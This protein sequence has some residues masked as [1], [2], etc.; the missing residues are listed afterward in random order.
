MYARGGGRGNQELRITETLTSQKNNT[1]LHT[2]SHT[3][4]H[5]HT[6]LVCH[7]GCV[8]RQARG[9]LPC[10]GGVKEP[11]L[12]LHHTHTA[13]TDG[14]I[15]RGQTMA[16]NCMAA[17]YAESAMCVSVRAASPAQGCVRPLQTRAHAH[18]L[19]TYTHTV[20]AHAPPPHTQS[21]THARARAHTCSSALN[22]C[23]RMRTLRVEPATVN[24]PPLMPVNTPSSPLTHSRARTVR[25]NLWLQVR[26]GV[27]VCVCVCARA[28]VCVHVCMLCCT[29]LSLNCGFAVVVAHN[30]CCCGREQHEEQC[31][32]EGPPPVW[33]YLC[34]LLL[35]LLL[36]WYYA[37]V[38][39]GPPPTCLAR[40]M[41]SRSP[42]PCSMAPWPEG[43]QAFAC[44]SIHVHHPI[45]SVSRL[46]A[47]DPPHP[48]S[49]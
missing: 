7:R 42:G 3:H 19:H 14:Y 29:L 48:P 1:Q 16:T 37:T 15:T 23:L 41:R 2:Q 13:R 8:C 18:M 39:N 20:L 44:L 17:L 22:S 36:L 47:A 5:T 28:C 35:L 9:D 31:E 38:F 12:H 6:H 27:C 33:L 49:S 11:L 45:T 10:L 43:A 30:V 46:Q 40:S 34:L 26:D 21:H 24:S 4:T 25:W 32:E